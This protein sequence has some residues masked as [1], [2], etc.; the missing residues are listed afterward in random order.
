MPQNVYQS[1]VDYAITAWPN[2]ER[3]QDNARPSNNVTAKRTHSYPSLVCVALKNSSIENNQLDN[4]LG[5]PSYF[6]GVGGLSE[7]ECVV[8]GYYYA[9]GYYY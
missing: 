7:V 6:A 9:W 5:L 3:H 4:S 1:T 2:N 8:G